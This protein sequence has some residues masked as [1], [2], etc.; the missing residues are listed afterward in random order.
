MKSIISQDVEMPEINCQ[1]K[2]N[3]GNISSVSQD[4]NYGANYGASHTLKCGA[5]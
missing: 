5:C 1:S 4:A 3:C 2:R